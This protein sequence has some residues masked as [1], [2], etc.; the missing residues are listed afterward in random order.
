LHLSGKFDVVISSGVIHHLEDPQRGLLNLSSLLEADGII[1]V[2]LYNAIGEHERL[3]GREL[4]HLMWDPSSG[5]ECGVQTMRD[6]GLRLEVKRYGSSSAQH[7]SD[8]SQLNIDVDAYV[9]P[10]VKAYRFEDALQ[11]LRKCEGLGWAAINNINLVESSKLIDLEEAACP[12]MK[13]F[14]QSLETLFPQEKLRRRFAEMDKLA[15]L[16]VIELKLQPT[17]FTIVSGR[18]HSY[19]RLG[20]RVIGNVL[21]L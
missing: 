3:M 18:G 16:R 1:V 20:P 9:H 6:L 2:W 12:D 15:K 17:G 21:G 13:C 5:L 10:I 4:L 19:V 14:C 11:M 8:V 7:A